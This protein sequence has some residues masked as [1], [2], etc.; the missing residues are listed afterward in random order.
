MLRENGIEPEVV[1]YLKTPP[2]VAA[3]GGLLK[4]LK[5]PAHHLLRAKEAEYKTAGLSPLSSDAKILKAIATHPIL[6]ERPIV[7]KG[8]KAVIGRPPERVRELL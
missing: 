1:E 3:V 6:L 4:A 5:I 8:K 7:V 2:T